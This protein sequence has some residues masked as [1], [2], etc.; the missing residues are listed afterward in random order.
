MRI[1]IPIVVNKPEGMKTHIM[2]PQKLLYLTM[3]QPIVGKPVVVHRLD[4]ETSGAVGFSQKSLFSL[5]SIDSWKIRRFSVNTGLWAEGKFQT[6]KT[7][8]KDKIDATDRRKRVVDPRKGQVAH[9]TITRP[10][11]ASKELAL[12]N[13]QLKTGRTYQ[14]VCIWPNYMPSLGDLFIATALHL[15]SCST[16]TPLVSY[17]SLNTRQNHCYMSSNSF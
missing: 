9:T 15:D 4:I 11:R 3:F 1:S 14:I 6:K 12:V 16:L 5:F 7:V 17:P 2:N 13:C 10:P 8:Y